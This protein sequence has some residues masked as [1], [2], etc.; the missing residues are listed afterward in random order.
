MAELANT[1]LSNTFDR[2]RLNTNVTTDRVKSI[3]HSDD[4]GRIVL[5][6]NV[7]VNTSDL[8]VDTVSNRVG[9]GVLNPTEKLDVSGNVKISD[10]LMVSGATANAIFVDRSL[11][12]V[13]IN[14]DTPASTLDVNGVITGTT[15]TDGT[16]NISGGNITGVGTITATTF[17]GTISEADGLSSLV[18]ISLSG[19]A[20][21]SATFQN[22]GDTASISVSVNNNSHSH[23][24]SNVTGLQT[25]LDGKADETVQVTGSAG[26]SGGGDLTTNRQITLDGSRSTNQMTK[27]NGTQIVDS[28]MSDD[29]SLV[30]VAGDI[31]VNDVAYADPDT[32]YN[33]Q[34]GASVSLDLS[35]SNNFEVGIAT[36]SGT[37]NFNN[38]SNDNKNGQTGVIKIKRLSGYGITDI[39]FSSDWKFMGSAVPDINTDL[40]ATDKYG[41]LDYYVDSGTSIRVSWSGANTT[42]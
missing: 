33:N 1:T 14:K 41:Y 26:L 31:K 4:N 24:I 42:L 21:G 3:T 35:L 17:N 28:I 6:G 20:T 23:I 7:E 15:I 39:S 11:S 12:R 29:G 27:W 38:P 32:T 40:D 34:T 8:V 5:T 10:D 37:F 25:E 9:I 30:T 2:W 22:A 16:V 19:D 36:T 18:T 13:A